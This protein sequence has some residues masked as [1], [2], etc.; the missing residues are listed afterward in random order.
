[1]LE[2]ERQLNAPNLQLAV[3]VDQPEQFKRFVLPGSGP[4]WSKTHCSWCSTTWSTC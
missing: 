4:S 2:I 3:Q 1:M